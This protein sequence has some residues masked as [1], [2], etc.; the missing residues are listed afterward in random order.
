ALG[1][2]GDVVLLGPAGR[3]VAVREHA[4]PVAQLEVPERIKEHLELRDRTC[5]FAYC[6][7]PARWT[8]KDHITP[9]AEGGETDTDNLACL[10]QHHHNLKTHTGWTYTMIEPGVFLWRSPH[11][12]TF[13]RDHQGTQ[14]LTPRPVSPPGAQ[15]Q[16]RPT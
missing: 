3:S 10:C 12:S 1:M 13:L 16:A 4:G 8:Q 11:G 6:N 7:R 9:H 15:Q 2:R 5:V 14:D